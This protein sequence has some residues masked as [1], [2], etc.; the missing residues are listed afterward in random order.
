MNRVTYTRTHK[1]T[2]W[3]HIVFY[4]CFVVHFV[5]SWLIMTFVS[6]GSLKMSPFRVSAA[7][8]IVCWIQQIALLISQELVLW[9]MHLTSSWVIDAASPQWAHNFSS[10]CLSCCNQKDGTTREITRRWQ[11]RQGSKFLNGT[12]KFYAIIIKKAWSSRSVISTLWGQ[13]QRAGSCRYAVHWCGSPCQ[14]FLDS[15]S[16]L[17]LGAQE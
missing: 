16:Q 15:L 6:F 3:P 11:G 17:Q 13:S 12:H 14:S 2:E 5:T 10:L 7:L 8:I 1:L 9:F 4:L